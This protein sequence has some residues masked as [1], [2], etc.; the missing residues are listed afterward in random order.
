MGVAPDDG[1]GQVGDG[2]RD[3]VDAPGIAAA[4]QL[5]REIAEPFDERRVPGG[6][7]LPECRVGFAVEQVTRPDGQQ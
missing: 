6:K 4:V 1:I 2:S 3:G 5:P 7:G